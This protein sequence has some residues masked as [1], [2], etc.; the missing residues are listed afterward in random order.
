MVAA[1]HTFHE[2]KARSETS[3][4]KGIINPYRAMHAQNKNTTTVTP[5]DA[6]NP[7]LNPLQPTEIAPFAALEMA[8][9]AL[10]AAVDPEVGTVAIVLA[11]P[12][13]AGAFPIV[14][15]VVHEL[16][17][18]AGWAVGVAGSPWWNVELPYMPIGWAESLTQPS[19]TPWS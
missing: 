1:K 9:A 6:V 15:T 2:E 11:K 12:V 18:G 4:Q 3:I 16:L 14:L 5:I 7:R 8:I 19:N 17:E 10:V 13:E